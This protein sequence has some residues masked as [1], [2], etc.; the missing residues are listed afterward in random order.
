MLHVE[1]VL[2]VA[3]ALGL[4]FDELYAV[5]GL[6]GLVGLVELGVELGEM[7]ENV[8]A[9]GL[10]G[11]YALEDGEG[12]AVVA[13]MEEEGGERAEVVGVGGVE[14]GGSA[15]LVEAE[16]VLTYADVG[17]AELVCG[18]GAVGVYLKAVVVEH[19]G[20]GDV[21][22]EAVSAC[23]HEEVV[24]SGLGCAGKGEGEEYYGV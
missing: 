13:L 20:L 1:L 2:G 21:A 6:D 3:E 16:A 12:F 24:Q 17:D 15:Y 8:G 10:E 18:F 11:G 14:L 7:A 23:L 22:V 5:E 9:L 4:A 19:D